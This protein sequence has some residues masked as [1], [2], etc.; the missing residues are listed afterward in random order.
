MHE[1]CVVMQAQSVGFHLGVGPVSMSAGHTIAVCICIG[2]AHQTLT[3]S[4]A[5]VNAE[6]HGLPAETLNPV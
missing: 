3:R 2:S 4:C 6:S 1:D 5:G